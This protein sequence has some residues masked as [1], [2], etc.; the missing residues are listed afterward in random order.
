[1]V[2]G[3]RQRNLGLTRGCPAACRLPEL[4]RALLFTSP[5]LHLRGA[6]KDRENCAPENVCVVPG[7]YRALI[8]F[9]HL[10]S[11]SKLNLYLWFMEWGRAKKRKRIV[12]EISGCLERKQAG[13]KAKTSTLGNL[14]LLSP[15]CSSVTRQP[16]SLLPFSA[17][18]TGLLLA[19]K[20]L[21]STWPVTLPPPR[22]LA[23]QD[24]RGA[25]F[26]LGLTPP[27]PSV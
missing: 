18:Q 7:T 2:L 16:L 24:L 11:H 22:V 17:E 23:A 12:S 14:A 3:V 15:C 20:W 19:G 1:M 26:Q 9:V 27:S 25:G 10:L 6:C 5:Y 21:T 8:A 13:K 4:F